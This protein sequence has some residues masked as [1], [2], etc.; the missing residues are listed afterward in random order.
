ML[1]YLLIPTM[2]FS[3]ASVVPAQTA[4]T[5]GGASQ[6]AAPAALS[7]ETVPTIQ[8][9]PRPTGD[10]A[11][12]SFGNG[13]PFS[14]IVDQ[15][16][17]EMIF[18]FDEVTKEMRSVTAKKGVILSS[19]EMTL[20]ADQLDYDTVSSKLVASGQRVVVRQG[21]MI[22]TC[23]L[24]KYNPDT[25]ESQLLGQPVVYNQTKDGGVNTVRGTEILIFQKDG[26]PQ[27]KVKG[28]FLK[29]GNTNAP[30]PAPV[31]GGAV[32]PAATGGSRPVGQGLSL[33]LGSDPSPSA[34]PAVPASN[35]I[36]PSSSQDLQL[37]S[38]ASQTVR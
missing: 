33:G 29:T 12:G 34:A 32:A 11:A 28:G 17:G 36:D 21:E 27:F 16:N 38:G 4:R 5:R 30:V 14:L 9:G 8:E 26:K 3:L 37:L 13:K 15:N 35:R 1:K 25:A 18:D 7:A 23:Q 2:L 31:P 22:A 10:N 24:F 6:A 20:N 19:E